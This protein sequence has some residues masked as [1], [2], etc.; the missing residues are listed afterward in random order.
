MEGAWLRGPA[1]AL[2]GGHS[3]EVCKA[4]C[5]NKCNADS[6]TQTQDSHLRTQ[7]HGVYCSCLPRRVNRISKLQHMYICLW[8]GIFSLLCC[9]QLGAAQND[10]N[11]TTIELTTTI[12]TTELSEVT[13]DLITTLT[14]E[15]SQSDDLWVYVV[16]A[17]GIVL[18]IAIIIIII[19]CIRK[20][21]SCRKKCCYCCR[22]SP[23]SPVDKDFTKPD[24]NGRHVN[25]GF[26]GGNPNDFQGDTQI[27]M[28]PQQTGIDDP[29]YVNTTIPA[30][31]AQGNPGYSPPESPLDDMPNLPP[32]S[33]PRGAASFPTDTHHPTRGIPSPFMAFPTSPVDE[34]PDRSPPAIPNQGSTNIKAELNDKLKGLPLPDDK[35]KKKDKK[36]KRKEE[37]KPKAPERFIDPNEQIREDVPLPTTSKF[38]HSH[39][40]PTS[41]PKFDFNPH[42]PAQKDGGDFGENYEEMSPVPSSPVRRMS[43]RQPT[44]VDFDDEYEVMDPNALPQKHNIHTPSHFTGKRSGPGVIRPPI[45]SP[46]V[47]SGDYGDDYEEMSPSERPR[48]PI[49]GGNIEHRPQIPIPSHEGDDDFGGDYE[50]VDKP[51][52]LPKKKPAKAKPKTQ[53][54]PLKLPVVED[55]GQDYSNTGPG[56]ISSNTAMERRPPSLPSSNFPKSPLSLPQ[57]ELPPPPPELVQQPSSPSHQFDYGGQYDDVELKPTIKKKPPVLKP[58]VAIKPSSGS[59]TLPVNPKQLIS[60]MEARSSA[61]LPPVSGI[62]EQGEEAEEDAVYMNYSPDQKQRPTKNYYNLP[63]PAK[64]PQEMISSSGY[65][66]FSELPK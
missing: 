54:K 61:T 55:F 6:T 18:L 9:V 16:I 23:P 15:E 38:D 2:T 5:T 36:K 7:K 43:P 56:A 50:D 12:V 26:D 14:T 24:N 35:P 41:P 52:V 46:P 60:P 42:L 27:E 19:I 51:F 28:E 10:T 22:A 17:A 49:P 37:S 1:P 66:Y 62:S 21:C 59:A 39:R 47:P 44:D 48:H 20:K 32:P 33:P 8:I 40:G 11:M 34:F 31:E 4:R 25:Q 63:V 13:T 53:K 30:S 64:K 65:T 3:S 58:K 57:E 45:I 29:I